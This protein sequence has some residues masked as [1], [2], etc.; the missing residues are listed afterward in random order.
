MGDPVDAAAEVRDIL[1]EFVTCSPRVLR[2]VRGIV[3]ERDRLRARVAALEGA[4]KP[5]AEATRGYD[6]RVHD[7]TQADIDR[8]AELLNGGG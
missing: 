5:L 6:G 3:E 4:L 8:A 1:N 7:I 2:I